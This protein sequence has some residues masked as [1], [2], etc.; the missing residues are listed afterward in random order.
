MDKE[1]RL[2][3]IDYKQAFG[4]EHGKKVIEDLKILA[5]FNHALIPLGND[6]HIDPYEVVRREGMRSVIIHIETM[7]NK[8]LDEEKGITNEQ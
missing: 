7:I 3:I 5:R 4:T 2:K 6:G 8:D 1:A